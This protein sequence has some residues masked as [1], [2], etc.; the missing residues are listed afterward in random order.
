PVPAGTLCADTRD[1]FAA[2]A[3]WLK[4]EI[5]Y[6]NNGDVSKLDQANGMIPEV[7][8]RSSLFKQQLGEFEIVYALN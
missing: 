4:L 7:D 5:D 1:L 8:A 3:R 2:I 6:Y